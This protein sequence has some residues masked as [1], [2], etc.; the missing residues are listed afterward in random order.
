MTKV[1]LRPYALLPRQ[2]DE[3]KV[4]ASTV[5]AWGRA[6]WLTCTDVRF[7]TRPFGRARPEPLA[8]PFDALLVIRDGDQV[9]EQTLYGVAFAPTEIEALPGGGFVLHGGCWPDRRNGQIFGGDG[10]PR[11]RVALGSHLLHMVADRRSNLWTGYADEGIY[12]GDPISAGALVRW[13]GRGNLQHGFY[14]PEPYRVVVEVDALNVTDS[15]VLAAYSGPGYPLA[16]QRTGEPLRVRP[17]PVAAACGLAVRGDRLLLF[18]GYEPGTDHTRGRQ[19]HHCLLRD[20][21]AVITG[22]AELCWP[23]GDLVR[24]YTRPIGR[25]PHLYLRNPR[26]MR[27]W[28]T[29]SVPD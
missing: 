19:V 8:L 3:R 14:P 27:M 22:R 12:S 1:A 2:Y 18:G 24:R 10:R 29:L 15:V 5:D 21:G 13:D 26:S 9:R 6:L 4:L 16:E 11:R 7:P 20:D 23:N 25:G 28:Y 17:L